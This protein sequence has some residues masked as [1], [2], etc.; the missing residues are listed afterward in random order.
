M[1]KNKFEIVETSRVLKSIFRHLMGSYISI[2]DADGNE[3]L[4]RM[5]QHLISDKEINH[6]KE[7]LGDKY[8]QIMK[9]SKMHTKSYIYCKHLRSMISKENDKKKKEFYL[10][11]LH[12][13]CAKIATI[14]LANKII[15]TALL[16]RCDLQNIPPM[17]PS[18]K[19]KTDNSQTLNIE[20]EM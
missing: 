11:K 6:L 14:D 12:D 10:N 3:R 17:H 7:D 9:I 2:D 18:Y 19:S 15:F 1:K 16:N 13:E 4:Y 5:N 20:T 8:S